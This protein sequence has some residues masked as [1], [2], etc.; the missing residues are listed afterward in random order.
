VAPTV[1]SLRFGFSPDDLDSF[2]GANSR[3]VDLGQLVAQ[4][5]PH[6][7]T[8]VPRLG[9]V[10]VELSSVVG[11]GFQVGA[12]GKARFEAGGLRREDRLDGGSARQQVP[13]RSSKF[14]LHTPSSLERRG[15]NGERARRCCMAT[16]ER[17]F[18]RSARELRAVVHGLGCRER[19]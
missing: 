9:R 3:L 1:D 5:S 2:D 12:H 8:K 7:A 6:P 14:R 17:Y 18:A 16:N 10:K 11:R 15:K 4:A 19:P 13:V